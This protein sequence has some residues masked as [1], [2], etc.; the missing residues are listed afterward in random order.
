[1]IATTSKLMS[2]GGYLVWIAI[3]STVL[4]TG[5]LALRAAH[6]DETSPQPVPAATTA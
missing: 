1:M 4:I 6:R 5:L 2:T 3:H